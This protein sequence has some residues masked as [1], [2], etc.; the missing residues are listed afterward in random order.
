MDWKE[1]KLDKYKFQDLAYGESFDEWQHVTTNTLDSGRWT[2]HLESIVKNIK[3][4]KF[5]AIYWERGLTEMQDMSMFYDYTPDVEEVK[6]VEKTVT[7]VD[8]VKVRRSHL[9]KKLTPYLGS[10]I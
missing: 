9:M 10:G 5:Y 4:N 3:T 1:L 6:P 2:K 7:T 8:W